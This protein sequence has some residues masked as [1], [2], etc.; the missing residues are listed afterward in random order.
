MC[1]DSET[2]TVTFYQQPTANA[3]I[4][5]EVCG[6]KSTALAATAFNYAAAPNVNCRNSHLGI[7]QRPRCHTHIQSI[8]SAPNSNVTVDYYGT[9]EFRYAEDNGGVCTD[10][11]TVTMTFYEKPCNF[12]RQRY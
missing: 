10:A 7:C 3:G 1:S 6:S 11:D 9:Y 4:D 2:I 8:G 12:C 5:K